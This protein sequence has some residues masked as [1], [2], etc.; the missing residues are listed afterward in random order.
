VGAVAVIGSD[1][2]AHACAAALEARAVETLRLEP[3]ALGDVP[4]SLDRSGL[5]LRRRPIAGLLWRALPQRTSLP[6]FA[7][8]DRGFALSELSAT[9]LAATQHPA[10]LAINRFDADTWFE[11]GD[12]TVWRRRLRA[13]KRDVCRLR[14]GDTDGG[15]WWRPYL[16]GPDRPPPNAVVKRVLA[17]ALA[18]APH[19]G[20]TLVVC[21]EP[22]G[23]GAPPAVVDAGRL[24]D[25]HGLALAAIGHDADG[26]PVK[27]DPHPFVPD[28]LVPDIVPL[29]VER[30]VEHLHR[31]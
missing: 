27:I 16:G 17:P 23:A 18:D 10:V 3:E 21:G 25:E 8:E 31:R 12:W 13:A 28:A 6:G 22:L 4:V 19:A 29:L 5:S 26:T 9:M 1:P 2:L 20:T 7:P 30:F 11:D 24:L 14:I 15:T